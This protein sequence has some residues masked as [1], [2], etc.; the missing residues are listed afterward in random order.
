[1]NSSTGP[2][3]AIVRLAKAVQDATETYDEPRVIFA[4]ATTTCTEIKPL[5]SAGP[6]AIRELHAA[7]EALSALAGEMLR[8]GERDDATLLLVMAAETEHAPYPQ[9]R[10]YWNYYEAVLAPRRKRYKGSSIERGEALLFHAEPDSEYG[11]SAYSPRTGHN[12]RY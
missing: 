7:R 8:A 6:A 12:H 1:M 4:S 2:D 3:A 11:D 10:G 5:H 9:Y